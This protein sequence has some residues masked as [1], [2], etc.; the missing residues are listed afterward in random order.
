MTYN[1]LAEQFDYGNT[2]YGQVYENYKF[3]VQFSYP[4]FSRS[5]RGGLNL[6]K[7]KQAEALLA[8]T[9]KRIDLQTKID[10]YAAELNNNL[11]QIDL[12]TQQITDYTALRDAEVAKYQLG[13]SNLFMV[14]SR[15]TKLLEAS[16]KLTELH[17]K[18]FTYWATL[19]W[20]LAAV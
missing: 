2:K 5:E 19:Q 17:I 8:Q 11:L 7:I 10:L 20:L 15:D 6:T 3:G 14:N 4:I 16:L 12:Y 18:H 1:A 9:Q 13:D